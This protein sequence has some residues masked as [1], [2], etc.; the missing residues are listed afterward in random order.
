[1]GADRSKLNRDGGAKPNP[2]YAAT[3]KHAAC[4]P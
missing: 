1:M 2:A 4:A 3:P